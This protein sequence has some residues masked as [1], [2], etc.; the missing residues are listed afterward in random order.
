[1]YK[2]SFSVGKKGTHT[3]KKNDLQK[4]IMIH[5]QAKFI[6]VGQVYLINIKMVLKHLK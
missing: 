1:M 6:T 3:Q 2:N 5:T 4:C